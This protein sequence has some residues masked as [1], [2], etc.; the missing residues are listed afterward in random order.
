MG[1]ISDAAA[2][3]RANAAREFGWRL[4]WERTIRA[5]LELW[6]VAGT[7]AILWT[8]RFITGFRAAAQD[9][10]SAEKIRQLRAAGAPLDDEFA[11]RSTVLPEAP[12]R[13][14]E[15][16]VPG[17]A[18]SEE[19]R[20]DVECD[21]YGEPRPG[22][23]DPPTRAELER[24]PQL[25]PPPP[26]P[27]P[28]ILFVP[29]GHSLVRR[30]RAPGGHGGHQHR[31]ETVE[32]AATRAIADAMVVAPERVAIQWGHAD[33]EAS[34]AAWRVTRVALDG[35]EIGERTWTAL[36]AD[37]LPMLPWAEALWARGLFCCSVCRSV[38]SVDEGAND[39]MLTPCGECG[40]AVLAPASDLPAA[41]LDCDEPNG[42]VI[43]RSDGYRA[44]GPAPTVPIERIGLSCLG[45]YHTDLDGVL[46]AVETMLVARSRA[47]LETVCTSQLAVSANDTDDVE[48]ETIAAL[49]HRRIMR[50]RAERARS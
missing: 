26:D 33:P 17:W 44:T 42:P 36:V 35:I 40:R 39:C 18:G 50:G 31:F 45:E 14:T 23:Y 47:R 41:H 13:D 29:G 28:V 22:E 25:R 24:V 3:E 48:L 30:C 15:S 12:P 5:L 16:L 34:D 37:R 19:G 49:V 1:V 20:A 27:C 43:G 46:V 10:I 8:G 2:M 11:P 32:Q 9:A 38:V 6:G 7:I 4:K 21:Q